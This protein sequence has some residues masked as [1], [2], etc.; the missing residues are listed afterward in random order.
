MD[1]HAEP[2]VLTEVA[3]DVYAYVQRPGGWCV[4]NAGVVA[5]REGA[6]VVDTLATRRRAERLSAGVDGLGIGPRRTV[7]NTHHHGDHNFGNTVFGAAAEV[8]VHERAV[9]EL[10]ET[11]L[12]LTRLWPD[13]EW[14]DVRVAQPTLTF[15][16]RIQLAVGDR[17]VEV[18][19]VGPA[20]TTNDIVV[21][22]PD[23]GVLFAG[24]V[25]LADCTPFALMGSIEGSL[26]AI[27]R[28]RGLGARTVVCGHG[29]VKGPEVFDENEAYLR[30]IQQ[31]AAAG[32]DEGWS[33]LET[34]RQAGLGDFAHLLDPE[35]LVGNLHRAF[36]ELRGGEPGEPLDVLSVFGEMVE[37]NDGN[38]P[39]C[40]A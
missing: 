21:W 33:P 17:R 7:V 14:G 15:A 9:A 18:T 39:S 29:P 24:D 20:H 25:V 3:E 6:V 40:L 16:D 37:Y 13:V 10:I 19:Y 23:S 31:I 36:A 27:E 35:R 30:R 34:A 12:A 38:L 4:S 8:I 32:L 2:G 26:K 28:L 11:G 5:G 1:A 22:V